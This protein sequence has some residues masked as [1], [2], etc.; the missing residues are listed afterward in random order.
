MDFW[1]SV[2]KRLV[3]KSNSKLRMDWWHTQLPVEQWQITLICLAV[4]WARLPWVQSRDFG[5]NGLRSLIWKNLA[6][7]HRALTSA[8]TGY[9]WPHKWS[10]ESMGANLHTKPTKPGG[11]DFQQEWKLFL[12]QSL[13]QLHSKVYVLHYNIITGVWWMLVHLV[14]IQS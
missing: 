11:E 6:D 3:T 14:Y 8:W 13:N 1:A 4:R 9:Y 7:L 10:T 5:D 12:L 2:W